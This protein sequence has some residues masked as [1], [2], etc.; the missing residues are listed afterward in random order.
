MVT[1][2]IKKPGLK[3]IKYI[4]FYNC[5]AANSGLELGIDDDDFFELEQ[6]YYRLAGIKFSSPE[7]QLAKIDFDLDIIES[8]LLVLLSLG[9][10][11]E[12]AEVALQY[13]IILT[14]SNYLSKTMEI[15]DLILSKRNSRK[16]VKSQ[17]PVTKRIPLTGFDVLADLALN[18]EYNIG[19]FTEVTVM[20]Y[21]GH[22]NALKRKAAR[23]KEQAAKNKIKRN[24]R[25][26][27]YVIFMGCK[28][29]TTRSI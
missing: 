18:L 11:D 6:E 12:L 17:I 24:G 21:I 25:Q 5:L 23:M 4:D 22:N 8:L 13:N 10:D 1:K 29:I 7:K 14:K 19:A 15:S 3:T 2:E 28:S 20:E 16:L 27:L 9:Y 26:R